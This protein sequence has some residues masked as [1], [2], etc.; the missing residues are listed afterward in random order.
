[1]LLYSLIVLTAAA[2]RPDSVQAEQHAQAYLARGEKLLRDGDVEN[3]LWNFQQAN[4]RYPNAA[5]AIG[6][7]ECYE[8]LGE[9]AYAVYYYRAYL[10]R[11]PGASDGLE[12]AERVSS[13]LFSELQNGRGFLEVE[14]PIPAKASIDGRA[15]GNLPVAAFLPL[16]EHEVAVEFPSGTQTRVVSLKKG[17]LT[18]S[19]SVEPPPDITRTAANLQSGSLTIPAAK[20]EDGAKWMAIATPGFISAISA[21]KLREIFS[22]EVVAALDGQFVQIVLPRE[23]S[24]VRNSFL[25]GFLGKS[26]ASFQ[27]SWVKLLFRGGGARPPLELLTD[28]DVVKAVA[29]RPGAIGIVSAGTEIAGVTRVSIR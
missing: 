24:P 12:I 5:A 15:A 17:K 16:G 26:N 25:L 8:R 3:A 1:M 23:G 20:E 21:D 27:A 18:T 7:A 28:A 10:K 4:A 6:A 11:S 9:K 29:T 13:T 2:P 22:G 19:L 14:A